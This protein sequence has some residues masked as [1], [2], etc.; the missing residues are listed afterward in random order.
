MLWEYSYRE[1]CKFVTW[2]DHDFFFTSEQQFQV[3]IVD[4]E[5]INSVWKESRVMHSYSRGPGMM[6]PI[7]RRFRIYL[8]PERRCWTAGSLGN[9]GYPGDC[10]PYKLVSTSSS[11][12][13]GENDICVSATACEV[14]YF[15]DASTV[16][17]SLNV[18]WGVVIRNL[19]LQCKG[20][21]IGVYGIH[22]HKN[23][24]SKVNMY[25]RGPP[26]MQP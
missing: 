21:V 5:Y 26:Y 24:I 6:P 16:Y 25:G 8:V 20:V 12:V 15:T 14:N 19:I 9:E 17:L 13:G 22:W 11:A 2:L 10:C 4:Y 18:L 7:Y 1:M 3:H 23:S